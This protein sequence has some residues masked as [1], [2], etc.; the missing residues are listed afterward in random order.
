MD[1]TEQEKGKFQDSIRLGSAA[2]GVNLVIYTDMTDYTLTEAKIK[3]LLKAKA[4]LTA[5]GV[6]TE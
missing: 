1:E 3:G 2:R 5:L 6:K 4:Y